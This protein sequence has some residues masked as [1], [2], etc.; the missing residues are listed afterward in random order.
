MPTEI[1]RLGAHAVRVIWADG[2]VSDYRNDHLR[3]H[4][5]CAGCRA[6]PRRSLPVLNAGSGD[7]YPR[8]IGLVGRYAISIEWSDGHDSGIYRYE[9]LRGLCPCATCAT[10]AR[11]VS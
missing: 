8:Q 11:A 7:L 3:A 5:P 6:R 4:C 9:T 10:A 1:R 2:H